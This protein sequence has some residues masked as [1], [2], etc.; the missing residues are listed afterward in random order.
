MK[1]REAFYESD[2]FGKRFISDYLFGKY[3]QKLLFLET[4]Y[5][6]SGKDKCQIVREIKDLLFTLFIKTSVVSLITNQQK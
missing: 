6:F 4:L 5:I 1:Y 3:H 2:G